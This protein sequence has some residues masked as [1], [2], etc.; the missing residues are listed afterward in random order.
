M[1]HTWV[2]NCFSVPHFVRDPVGGWRPERP[3]FTVDE[4]RGPLSFAAVNSGNVL[5]PA[6]E[7]CSR[8]GVVYFGEDA[9]RILHL[10][11]PGLP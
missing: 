1:K 11:Q 2:N 8:P 6:F 10:D 3:V 7:G 4:R 9:I 5:I